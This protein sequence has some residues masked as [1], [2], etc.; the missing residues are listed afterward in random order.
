MKFRENGTPHQLNLI[1]NALLPM[2]IV[3]DDQLF[4][5]V[6][7]FGLVDFDERFLPTSKPIQL[8]NRIYKLGNN[9]SI[10]KEGNIYI[11][12]IGVQDHVKQIFEHV[13]LVE[14]SQDGEKGYI[15]TDPLRTYGI[16]CSHNQQSCQF[17]IT[18]KAPNFRVSANKL[19]VYWVCK[20]YHCGDPLP[21]S[22]GSIVPMGNSHDLNFN[23][24]KISIRHPWPRATPRISIEVEGNFNLIKTEKK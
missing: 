5:R 13:V 19:S 9:N 20:N 24:L 2:D 15:Y 7:F 3:N 17:N 11:V 21:G 8:F 16:W 4:Y 14:T 23:P 12:Y 22:P 10:L 6:A 1:R 18:P